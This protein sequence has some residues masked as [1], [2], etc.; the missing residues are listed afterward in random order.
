MRDFKN[1]KYQ[2]GKS[3]LLGKNRVKRVTKEMLE[4]KRHLYR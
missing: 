4:V 2:K 1:A 3:E